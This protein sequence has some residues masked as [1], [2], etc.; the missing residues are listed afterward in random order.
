MRLIRY[1]IVLLCAQASC[2]RTPQTNEKSSTTDSSTYPLEI[3]QFKEGEGNPV[4]T[5][6]GADTWDQ[7]IRERGYILKEDGMY[8]MWYTGYRENPSTDMHL[9]YATSTDGL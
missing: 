6:T 1:A 4:F 2:T 9:G 8:H 3:L 5:G 7:K